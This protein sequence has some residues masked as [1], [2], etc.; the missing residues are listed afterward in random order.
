MQLSNLINPEAESQ[1]REHSR[2]T[3]AENHPR[4]ALR[5]LCLGLIVFAILVAEFGAIYAGGAHPENLAI[6]VAQALALVA[7]IVPVA[8][9]VALRPAAAEHDLQVARLTAQLGVFNQGAIVAVTDG[10]GR[11]IEVNDPFCSLSGYSRAELLGQNHRMLNSSHHPQA[12]FM[13]LYRTITTGEVW[14]GE[15][16]NVAKDGSYYWT[17]TAIVPTLNGA[18][19]IVRYTSIGADITARKQAEEHA[20]KLGEHHAR[21]IQGSGICLWDWDLVSDRFEVNDQWASLL[22]YSR[23]EITL[24]TADV[25]R[26]LV[27]PKDLAQVQL[28]LDR[29]CRGALPVFE[30]EAR[31]RHRRGHWVW[32]LMRGAVVERDACGL[33]LQVSGQYFDVTAAKE[34]AQRTQQSEALLKAIVDVLPQHVFWKDR[35]GNF[36]GANRAFRTDSGMDEVIGKNDRDMPW[37]SGRANSFREGDR[38]IMDSRQPVLNLEEQVAGAG[39]AVKWLTTSKV[40][41]VAAR[42]DVWGLLGVSQDITTIKQTQTDLIDAMDAAEAANRAKGEFLA[43]MSHEIRTPMNGIM[44]FADLLLDT[45]LDTDQESFAHMIRDSAGALTT[46]IDDILDFSN[47]EAG[48]ISVLKAP[49]DAAVVAREV[50]SLLR[51]HGAQKDIRFTLEWNAGTTQRL[52]ADAGRFRQ[53]L[54]NL[55]GNAVKF[56]ASGHVAIKAS[57]QDAATVLIEVEDT[58]IGIPEKHIDRLFTR[59][60]QADSSNTR[61]YGGTGLGLAI[62]KQLTELMDGKIGA[63]SVIDVGSTFWFT[64]PAAPAEEINKPKPVTA[65][66]AAHIT[67]DISDTA[68]AQQRRVLVVEDNAVNRMLA[69][70]LLVRLGCVVDLAENG[71]IACQQME[72]Q[73]YDLV[74]MDCQMP[75][76]D[77]FEATRLIRTGEDRGRARTPIV[78]LTANAMSQD[79]E[80][81]LAAGMDDYLSKPFAAIDIERTLRRWCGD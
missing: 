54:L 55:V 45:T 67:G 77:G 63:R 56:T 53:I 62:A 27:H 36:L 32:V 22:G 60:T 47:L 78:A 39:G 29:H 35:E 66:R 25:W 14:R 48:R 61:K 33:A 7:V 74:L 8:Y 17:H 79:R 41:L 4:L 38:K 34:A 31:L 42:G 70:R 26:D 3:V 46:I 80:R 9:L 18:G 50:I 28:R 72:N 57:Q 81:C 11:I 59:F 23:E 37:A 15:I 13:E 12:F 71:R 52:Y 24:T 51:P 10:R 69:Q 44:G 20:R 75:E 21:A 76:V 65:A 49:F 1:Y 30:C 64:M 43:T 6:A 40:P 73:R 16:C 2:D 68:I 5:V 19:R 58:G